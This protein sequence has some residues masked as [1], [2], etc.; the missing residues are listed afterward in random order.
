[1][2]G[3]TNVPTAQG[4]AD[5]NQNTGTSIHNCRISA[6]EDFTLGGSSIK[7]YLG[8][9]WKEYSRTVFI[10][11]F[12]DDLFDPL[13]SG[14]FALSTHYYAECNNTGP[15]SG[16]DNRVKW[17]GYHLINAS[18]VSNFTVTNFIS[19]DSWLAPTGVPFSASLLRWPM[20]TILYFFFFSMV[21]FFFEL[22]LFAKLENSILVMLPL[23]VEKKKANDSFDGL[24]N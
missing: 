18:D 2:Q 9:P 4:R 6:A 5:P 20:N 23:K 16:S 21:F 8:R 17:P 11:S 12:I 7:T 24:D 3:Q 10:Q 13:G 1:M 15:G 14:D 22:L 19:G